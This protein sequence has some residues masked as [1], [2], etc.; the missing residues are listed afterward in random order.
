RKFVWTSNQICQ[1]FDSILR[2]YPINSFMMWE[3]TD[4]EIK[5]NYKFYQFLTKYCQRF[6]EE[7]PHIEVNVSSKNFKAIIDGQ[8]RLKI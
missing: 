3:I 6:N 4:S 7:N 5:K 1:L 8:Q 2:G